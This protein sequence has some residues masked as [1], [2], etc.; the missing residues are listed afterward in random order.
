[1]MDP[2]KLA[3]WE[4]HKVVSAG[5]IVAWLALADSPGQ[6]RITD[7]DVECAD[8]S[9]CRVPVAADLCARYK[10]EVGDYYVV[11]QD[12]YASLSPAKAFEDGYTRI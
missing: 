11:Y 2:M 8:G 3:R 10:P 6:Y 12:G 4:C 5:K 1:M 7:I 9:T